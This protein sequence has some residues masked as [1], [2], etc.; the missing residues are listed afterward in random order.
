MSTTRAGN[1]RVD[2]TLY[3]VGM[4]SDC[5]CRKPE[6][7]SGLIRPSIEHTVCKICGHHISMQMWIERL[8][9]NCSADD[10]HDGS[11]L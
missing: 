2:P 11:E 8:T 7:D 1:V 3:D 9:A 5:Q 10:G 4:A 6:P